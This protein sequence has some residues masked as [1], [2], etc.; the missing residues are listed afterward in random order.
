MPWQLVEHLGNR[1]AILVGDEAARVEPV[2]DDGIGGTRDGVDLVKEI[3]RGLQAGG[4]VHGET[5]RFGK[6]G[7]I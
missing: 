6:I 7:T 3:E 5:I 1:A 4:E 2:R